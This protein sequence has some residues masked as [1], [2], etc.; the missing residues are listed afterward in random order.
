VVN[1]FGNVFVTGTSSIND[2]NADF[3]TVKYD[4]AGHQLGAER[5]GPDV[6]AYAL[7]L[8]PAGDV[9]LAGSGFGDGFVTAKYVQHPIPI[10]LGPV[11]LL[12]NGQL[13]FTLTCEAQH[14]YEIQASTD[15]MR[16]AT[17]R[18]GVRRNRT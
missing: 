2:T 11:T 3:A 13:Q 4:S 5:L 9:Y 14:F 18:A 8:D 12:T 15:L 16:W 1:A 7:S 6:A 17:V 10:Q